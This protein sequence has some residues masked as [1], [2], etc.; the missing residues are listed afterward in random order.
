VPSAADDIAPIIAAAGGMIR[1]DEFMEL[2]LYGAHGFYTDGGRAGRRGDFITSPEV[3]PLFGAVLARWIDAEWQR[4]GR[5]HDFTVVEVGAGPGT[6]ARAITRCWASDPA[7]H[8][9][10][11]LAVE[12]SAAQR[13][14]HPEGVESVAALPDGQFTGVVLANELL[15]NLP[16]RLAVFDDGWREAFVATAPDGRFGEVLRLFDTPPAVLPATAPHG[17]RAPWQ[18]QAGV[19][20]DDMRSRLSTGSILVFDYG[21]A[22]TAELAAR[23][24]REWLRTYRGH[25]RGTHY[26]R[27]PG[28]QDITADVAIDQLPEPDE[29]RTQAQFL[30]RWGIDDLVDEGRA[31][32]AAAAAAPTVAAM[33]MRSRVREAE[34]LLDPAGLGAFLSLVYRSGRGGE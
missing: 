14:M 26:L 17:A 34:A 28:L 3:G 7:E 31:A 20:I 10:R 25:E 21:V 32:W 12:R 23:P 24:W 2:A 19:W 30:Q 1:F 29:V 5:P 18:Q 27:D 4:L 33:S 16:F 11:Y 22:R 8:P 13:A 6:L 15:D 9:H